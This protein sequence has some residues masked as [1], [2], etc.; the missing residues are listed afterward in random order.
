MQELAADVARIE[1]TRRNVALLEAK[2]AD[3]RAQLLS[4][5][6]AQVKPQTI[7]PPPRI[8]THAAEGRVD[9]A[10][11]SNQELREKFAKEQ[12]RKPQNESSSWRSDKGEVEGWTPRSIRRMG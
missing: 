1:G 2:A 12:T 7:E 11:V 3:E 4:L 9:P 6:T 8:I 5:R 10:T